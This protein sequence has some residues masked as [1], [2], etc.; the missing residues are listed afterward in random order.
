MTPF[1]ARIRDLRHQR[2]ITLQQMAADLN[3]SAAYL[4]ALEHGK[5]GKPGPGLVLELCGYFGLIW[6]E[7]E[8]LKNLAE[9]SRP[10]VTLDTSG[11]SP[12]TTAFANRLGACIRYL[13]D[14]AVATLDALLARIQPPLPAKRSRRS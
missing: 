5:R 14:E 8:A 4:S 9:V 12:Q 7:A 3:V 11:L 6:D 1:G 10:K 13:D 2:G